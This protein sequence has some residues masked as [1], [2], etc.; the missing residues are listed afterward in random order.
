M[1][2]TIKGRYEGTGTWDVVGAYDT[3]EELGKATMFLLFH[4]GEEAMR[5][6][7]IICDSQR[8]DAPDGFI[9]AFERNGD[10]K[11]RKGITRDRDLLDAVLPRP[12]RA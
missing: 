2:Y 1:R 4:G 9:A 12:R 10:L 7:F 6:E 5:G 11:E 3:L 8:H